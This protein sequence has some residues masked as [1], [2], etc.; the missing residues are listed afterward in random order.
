MR[1]RKKIFGRL[2]KKLFRSAR[3]MHNK[4]LKHS[5]FQRGGIRL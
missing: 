1:A 4:N 3:Y 2:N 5:L